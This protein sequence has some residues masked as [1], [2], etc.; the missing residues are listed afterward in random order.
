MNAS[1]EK[2]RRKRWL[3]GI[4]IRDTELVRRGKYGPELT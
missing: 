4:N 1:S 2:Q 3:A